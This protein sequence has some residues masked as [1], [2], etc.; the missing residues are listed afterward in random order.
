MPHCPVRAIRLI[1]TLSATILAVQVVTAAPALAQSPTGRGIDAHMHILSPENWMDSPVGAQGLIDAAIDV[2][3]IV[4]LVDD[5]EIERAVLISGAYFF[6]DQERARHENEFTSQQVRAYPERFVGLCSVA[7]LQPWALDELEYCI[8]SLELQGLK[9]HLVAE[10]M[11]LTNP[12]HLG[13]IAGLLAEAAEL[14][15]GLPVLIDFNWTDDAQTFSLIQLAFTNPSVNIVMAH[16][17][18]HHYSELASIYLY[19][20]LLGGFGENLYIDISSTLFLYPPGSPPF[21]NYMWHLRRFGMDR[22]LFGS[23]YPVKSSS[24]ALEAL[25]AMGFTPEEQNQ[26][27]QDNALKVY[28][29]QPYVRR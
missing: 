13:V 2:Q 21:E 18:G 5:A 16:G 23:D 25:E 10:N 7:P 29:F 11:N 24:E 1:V 15:P 28:G 8:T 14:K 6:Q 22:V 12:E 17:L 9:L 26:I 27:L 19:R 3:T 20:E 4:Q